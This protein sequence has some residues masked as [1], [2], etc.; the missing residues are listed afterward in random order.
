VCTPSTAEL[1]H[2]L[3]SASATERADAPLPV[4]LEVNMT[5]EPS[6]SGVSPADLPALAGALAGCAHLQPTGLMTIARLGAR[7]AELRRT[8]AGLRDLLERLR[9][10]HPGDWRHLSMGMTDDYEIAIE[11]GAT[12][13]RLGRALF[14]ERDAA[15]HASG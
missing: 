10:H 15:G 6:K 12:I 2:A 8:F 14:G 4:L 13:V 9:A 7:D 5:A 3:D 11:E 1:A